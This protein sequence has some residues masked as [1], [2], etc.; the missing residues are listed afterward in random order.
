MAS[1]L[2][3]SRQVKHLSGSNAMGDFPETMPD[4]QDFLKIL[5]IICIS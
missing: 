5:R 4:R 1:T 2:S 3:E